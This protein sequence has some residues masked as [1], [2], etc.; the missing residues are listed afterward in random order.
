[1][2]TTSIQ[3]HLMNTVYTKYLNYSIKVMKT[4]TTFVR[5]VWSRLLNQS[6]LIRSTEDLSALFT[7]ER[8]V[9]SAQ[10]RMLSLPSKC[11]V[12]TISKKKFFLKSWKFVPQL[13][14]KM[15]E[16][17][18]WGTLPLARTKAFDTL[19]NRPQNLWTKSSIKRKNFPNRHETEGTIDAGCIRWKMMHGWKQYLP[20][21]L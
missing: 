5:K 14:E 20:H 21:R 2:S 3:I 15:R 12:A 13:F 18:F 16:V 10:R 11:L 7:A 6:K 4:Q 19:E 9:A 17:R 8:N 1:M